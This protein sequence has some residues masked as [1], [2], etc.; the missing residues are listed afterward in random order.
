MD[1]LFEADQKNQYTPAGL[2]A[3]LTERQEHSTAQTELPAY[4]ADIVGGVADHLGG[5]DHTLATYLQGWTIP[6]LP[7]V[8]RA[9]LRAATWELLFNDEIDA[10]VVITEAANLAQDLSTDD[11]PAFV[12]AVLDRLRVLAPTLVAEIRAAEEDAA[13][14]KVRKE[15][16]ESEQRQP[17]QDVPEQDVPE[18]D[19]PE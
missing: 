4:S 6:R 18:Q 15:S 2:R 3:L 13:A 9:I 12:N 8:D 19:V 1:V 11:S 17:E 16:A 10:P 7:A 5:I 14:R